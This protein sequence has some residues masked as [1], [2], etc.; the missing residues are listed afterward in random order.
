MLML[1]KVAAGNRQLGVLSVSQAIVLVDRGRTRENPNQ[2]AIVSIGSAKPIG[3]DY[4]AGSFEGSCGV[5]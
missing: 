3:F 1:L 2:A 4:F 5:V